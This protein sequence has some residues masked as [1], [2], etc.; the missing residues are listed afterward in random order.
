M[1]YKT[2]QTVNIIFR[3]VYLNTVPQMGSYWTKFTFWDL[4]IYT[5]YFQAAREERKQD[6]WCYCSYGFILHDIY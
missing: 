2:S 1:K 4:Y 6:L 3:A 5:K